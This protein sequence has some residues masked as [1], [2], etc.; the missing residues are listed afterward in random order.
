MSISFDPSRQGIL[1][2]VRVL[3]LSRLLAGNVAS[4]LLGDFGAEVIKVEPPQ[5]DPLRAW[6]HDGVSLQWKTY[7][8]NKRSI[9]LDLRAEAGRQAARALAAAS[10][11]LIENFRP[12]T[13]ERMGMGPAA[14]HEA[15]PGLVIV[16]ISG[17]GQTGPYAGRPG[18]GTIV[19]AM[20]GLASQNGF[21][22]R[23]PVLPPLG[24]ADKITG[25]YG[26]MAV[27]MALLARRAGQAQGQVIDL[28]LLEPVVSLLG[29]EATIY[30]ATGHVNERCGSASNT[31]SPRNVYRCADERYIAVSGSMQSMA[32]RL[33]I[34]IGRPEMNDDPRFATNAARVRH[35]A[36]VDAIVGGWFAARTLAES[37]RAMDEADVTAGPVNEIPD[38]V[39]DPHVREREVFVDVED[40]ELGQVKLYNVLPR[41][42]ETPGVWRYPAPDLGEHAREILSE[43]GYDPALIEQLAPA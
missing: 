37:L 17:F 33:F 1:R 27:S 3:D 13:L 35:R 11:V 9:M 34:A 20:S 2:G 39:A 28:S 38:V 21:A 26:A 31:T 24:F 18:F 16:R 8:R 32:Q 43:I 12:G 19:E 4:A 5:G 41:L 36:E 7:G 30:A 6:K 15:N 29:V 23:E 10:D 25:V 14:L 40:G 22:D 42:S